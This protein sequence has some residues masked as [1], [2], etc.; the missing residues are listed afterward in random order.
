MSNQY[1]TT[2]LT[3]DGSNDLVRHLSEVPRGRVRIS[4]C[5]D[6]VD[7]LAQ[8]DALLHLTPE[9]PLLALAWMPGSSLPGALDH[10][11]HAL[12]GVAWARWPRWYGQDAVFLHPDAGNG[13]ARDLDRHVIARL[14]VT[15]PALNRI[16]AL[17]AAQHCRH[18]RRPIVDGFPASVQARQL[19]L[20]LAQPDLVLLL[21]LEKAAESSVDLET[22]ARSAA[23]A[24]SETGARV[25]VFLPGAHRDAA[26][27]DIISYGAVMLPDQV[28]ATLPS[29][30]TASAAPPDIPGNRRIDA[31]ACRPQQ[32]MSSKG[33]AGPTPLTAASG[34]S[35]HDAS[36]SLHGSLPTPRR[37]DEFLRLVSPPIL[38]CP[39]PASPG[40]QLLARWLAR[41]AELTCL[42]EF[43]QPIVTTSGETFIVDLLWRDGKLT[44]EV[45]GYSWHSSPHA[46]AADRH[47]DYRLLCD[48]YRTLRL[49]HDEVMDDPALQCEKI[50]DAVRTIRK[51]R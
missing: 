27:L 17:Q 13:A 30:G 19:M 9:L 49:P 12:A 15:V 11:V 40:E 25:A 50:R 20:A 7:A 35:Q 36:P 22:F 43:N 14:G 4:Y 6:V 3:K 21:A 33:E 26:E 42:F 31:P 18:G 41:D 44:V 16:W 28:P 29:A 1:R 24:A 5:S 38:G 37:A 2:E 8:L 51:E 34:R 10:I 23:W 32:A 39:H 45:D 48:G 47:R 46:F